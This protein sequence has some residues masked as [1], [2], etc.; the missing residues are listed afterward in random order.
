MNI[1]EPRS[2]GGLTHVDFVM[3]DKIRR[4]AFTR[5]AIEDDLGA[6]EGLSPDELCGFVRNHSLQIKDAVRRKL[7]VSSESSEVVIIRTGDLNAP[8]G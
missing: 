2:S 5:G 1:G 3:A 6:G 7:G 8:L 4:L